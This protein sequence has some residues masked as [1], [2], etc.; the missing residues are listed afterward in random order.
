[1]SQQTQTESRAVLEL[2]PP[3]QRLIRQDPQR[4]RR[5][6]I[7]S[8]VLI[9]SGFLA[10]VLPLDYLIFPVIL[11]VALGAFILYLRVPPIGLL[12]VIAAGLLVRFEL[13]TGT[14]SAINLVIILIPLL[15]AVW[16]VD[17]AVRKRG[18]QFVTSR[19]I[20]PLLVLAVISIISFG[21]GQLPWFLYARGAPL[22]SQV[23]GLFLILLSVGA[24]IL[25]A[26]LI[27]DLPWL[28]R[29]TW[30]FLGITGLYM[31][32][33]AFPP[34]GRILFQILPSGARGS[35]LY[36][37]LIAIA[38]SQVLIN[39]KLNKFARIALIGLLLLTFYVSFFRQFGWKSGWIPPLAALGVII[40]LRYPKLGVVL[41]IAALIFLR[42]LP[43]ELISTDEY[44]Y[45]TRLAAWQIIWEEIIKVNPLLGLGP[46]NYYYFTPLYPI[47]GFSVEFNSHNN[48]VDLVAQV[49]LLGLASFVWFVFEMGYLGLNLIKKVPDGFSNAYVYGVLGGL[50]GT[51]VAG[52]L[53]DWIIPFVYNIG[54]RGF[55][56]SVIGWMFL[57]GL[58][59][60][61]RVYSNQKSGSSQISS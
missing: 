61:E 41:A 36:V 58:V 39:R 48:Y 12:A 25:V 27:K 55:R 46:A 15:L 29:M 53:G 4:L 60:V 56:A 5:A 40:F 2:V 52:M 7:V 1:L 9:L 26:N 8:S 28:K 57:G 3:L 13:G 49:G 43:A 32:A 37:W 22:I 33:S 10:F 42:D 38:F 30:F 47:L 31:L 16:I 59:V 21:I 23:A 35:L 34:I 6:L 54:L 14:N 19:P 45:T 17:N 11:T 18:I 51:L 20:L 44:S 50:A 24:F